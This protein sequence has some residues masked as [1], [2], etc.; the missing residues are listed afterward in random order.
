MLQTSVLN[1]CEVPLGF[2]WF[3]SMIVYS[4]TRFHIER[5]LVDCEQKLISHAPQ[6]ESTPGSGESCP[7]LWECVMHHMLEKNNYKNLSMF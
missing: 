7:E 2:M 1:F 4:F 6:M 5:I 3:H